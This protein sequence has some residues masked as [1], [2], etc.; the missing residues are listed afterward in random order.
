MLREIDT[1][2]DYVFKTMLRVDRQTFEEILSKIEAE[3]GGQFWIQK[4]R[5]WYD[6]F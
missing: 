3:A 4:N 1:L 5:L 2:P 6:F